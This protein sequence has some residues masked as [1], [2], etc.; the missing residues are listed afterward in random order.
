MDIRTEYFTLD[1]VSD[2]RLF[3]DD[4]R[5]AIRE[6][7][8]VQNLKNRAIVE[9][10]ELSRRYWQTVGIHYWKIV[11]DNALNVLK[12]VNDDSIC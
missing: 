2:F 1:W 12:E 9:Q 5:A 4:G 7:V 11:T 3:F 10:L 6:F 8:K